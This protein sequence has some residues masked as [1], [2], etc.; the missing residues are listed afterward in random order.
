[1]DTRSFHGCKLALL[2]GNCVLVYERDEHVKFAG[3][4]DLPGGG[5]EGQESPEDCVLRELEEEFGL[6]FPANRLEY[7][8]RY[9]AAHTDSYAYFFVGRLSASEVA[10]IRFGNEGKRWRLMEIDEYLDHPE[11]LPNHKAWLKEYRG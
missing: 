8:K 11:A 5:R 2:Q 6:A 9:A 7:R 10:S 1:M 4:W 3:M